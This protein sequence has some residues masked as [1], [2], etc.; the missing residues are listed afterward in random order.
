MNS[1]PKSHYLDIFQVF[2]GIAVIMVA[3]LA[4]V[5]FFY[6]AFN[7]LKL[8]IIDVNLMF[9]LMAFLI[10]FIAVC[11]DTPKIY[12]YSLMMKVGNATYP[13][14][15][16]HNNLQMILTRLFPKITSIGSLIIAL[17]LAKTLSSI[18]GY[19]YYLIYEKK[20]IYIIKS[21]LVK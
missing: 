21:K 19:G 20:G 10:I 15:L 6:C 4:I 11:F 18:V 7:P 14:Y 13:I 17:V 1:Y 8:F 3:V 16:I 5:S 12:K 2:R 9:A